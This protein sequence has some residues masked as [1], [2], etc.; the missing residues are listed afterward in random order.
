[1]FRTKRPFY[2]RQISD[3]DES[4]E[5]GGSDKRGTRETA[6][7]HKSIAKR[8]GTWRGGVKPREPAIGLAVVP[9]G[10]REQGEE[11]Y[12]RGAVLGP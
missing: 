2:L 3:T 7:R 8:A 4:A 1:M 5:K 12:G 6:E 9:W 11:D 10:E